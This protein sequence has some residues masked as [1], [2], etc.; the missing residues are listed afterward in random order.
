MDDER[1]FRGDT[2]N[3]FLLYLCVIAVW[4]K[5]LWYDEYRCDCYTAT[6]ERYN[7]GILGRQYRHEGICSLSKVAFVTD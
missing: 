5:S 2:L 3:A 7:N 4:S 1:Y 6:I